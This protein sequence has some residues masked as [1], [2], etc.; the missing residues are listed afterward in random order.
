MTSSQAGY[1]PEAQ[2][3]SANGCV[4]NIAMRTD[5]PILF[6]ILL[7]CGEEVMCPVPDIDI[8]LLSCG[9]SAIS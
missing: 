4:E 2:S 8:L 6:Y 5:F 7:L 9:C 1:A 3:I